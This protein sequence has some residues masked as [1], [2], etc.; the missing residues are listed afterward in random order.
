[1]N[2]L[3]YFKL[4]DAMEILNRLLDAATTKAIVTGGFVVLSFGFDNIHQKAL[5]ALFILMWADCI[6]SIWAAYKT[7][8]PIQSSKFFR[9]PVKIVI[10]FGLIY[11]AKI[12]EYGFPTLL[13]VLDETVIAFCVTTELISIMENIHKLGYPVPSKLF[14][15]LI[16]IRDKQ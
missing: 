16:N 14:Q 1:M 2:Y 6:T 10:Y 15:K 12:T 4:K 13:G 9:T 11:M 8:I 5:L 3:E 7:G